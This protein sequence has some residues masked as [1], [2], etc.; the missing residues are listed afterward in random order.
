LADNKEVL[1]EFA[2][3]KRKNKEKLW[4]LVK[5]STGVEFNLDSLFDI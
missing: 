4:A 3:I 1:K 2:A 5:S